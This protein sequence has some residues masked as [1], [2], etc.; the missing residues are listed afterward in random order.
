MLAFVLATGLGLSAAPGTKDND[1]EYHRVFSGFFCGI[2]FF[3]PTSGLALTSNGLLRTEGSLCKWKGIAGWDR[4]NWITDYAG[5]DEKTVYFLIDSGKDVVVGEVSDPDKPPPGGWMVHRIVGKR[6]KRVWVRRDYAWTLVRWTAGAGFENVRTIPSSAI[7]SPTMP[8]IC[9]FV[10]ANT[11]AFGDGRQVVVTRDGGKTWTAT[12]VSKPYPI[13]DMAWLDT[14][15]LAVG[16]TYDGMVIG[17]ELDADNHA[18]QTWKTDLQNDIAHY[19]NKPMKLSPDGKLLWVYTGH[20]RNGSPCR[21]HGIDPADGKVLRTDWPGT[22]WYIRGF[23]PSNSSLYVWS[24]EA[25]VYDLATKRI[26]G[27]VAAE[28]KG[29]SIES[30]TPICGRL[31]MVGI[32]NIGQ[33][34]PWDGRSITLPRK[35]LQPDTIHCLPGP[36]VDNTLLE[37]AEE[38]RPPGDWPSKR[39]WREHEK[40]RKAVGFN[41]QL[42][43]GRRRSR[44]DIDNYREYILWETEEFRKAAGTDAPAP[45]AIPPAPFVGQTFLAPTT[46]KH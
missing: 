9:T 1:G 6:G 3:S 37:E 31:A 38:R 36:V 22:D 29:D 46:P 18:R 40:A 39:E 30:I 43:I 21:F 5:G 8:G 7:D 14:T 41:R 35:L 15:H 13:L 42:E 25:L 11:G 45:P 27:T 16:Q 17:L 19:F 44:E 2:R 34:L 20:G 32:R 33:L 26:A 23:C 12:E 28:G 24:D 10:D 4:T